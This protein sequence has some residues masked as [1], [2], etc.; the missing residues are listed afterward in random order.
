MADVASLMPA[1]QV[2]FDERVERE[3]AAET[4]VRL[5]PAVRATAGQDAVE[6]LEQG[7]ARQPESFE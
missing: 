5:W 7:P 3:L 4:P 1:E 6:R 2:V